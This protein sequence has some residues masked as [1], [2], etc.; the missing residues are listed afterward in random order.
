MLSRAAYTNRES[1]VDHLASLMSHH[2]IVDTA[3]IDYKG[4]WD[5]ISELM[6]I[7]RTKFKWT[8]E[9]VEYT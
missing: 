5:Y 4:I 6:N 3:W 9:R 1:K 8:L 2:S 7:Y